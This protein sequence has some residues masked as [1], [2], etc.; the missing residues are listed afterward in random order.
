MSE[1]LPQSQID[2]LL[3][4]LYS[5]E[6]DSDSIESKKDK[7]VKEYDF[8]NPKKV[9]KEELK[10]LTGIYDGFARHL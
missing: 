7:K 4:E 5:G 8:K 9:T 1:I 10:V 3:N 2:S 6:I